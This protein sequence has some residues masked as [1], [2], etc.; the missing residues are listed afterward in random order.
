M[1]R[2]AGW[3]AGLRRAWPAAPTRSSCPSA[4]ST[5]TRSARTC[6]RRH[7]RGPHVLDR[8]RQR[9]RA[10][11]ATARHD[12]RRTPRPTRSATCASAA[13]PS[14]S[15]SEIEQ[16]TGYETRMTILG[17]V[18][19]G[20][21]PTAYDRV[22]ATRFGVEAVDAPTRGE[23]GAMVALRG[24]DIVDACRWPRRSP[25]PSCSTP[26]STRP[27]RSSSGS[28][29][30]D[31]LPDRVATL[32]VC[33]ACGRVSSSSL[34][35]SWPPAAAPTPRP[36]T[37]TSTRSTRP[38]ASS[39]RS[40][41]SSRARSPRRARAAQDRQ[42]LDGF[43]QAIDKVV[44]DFRAV[45][46]PSKVKPL[47]DKLIAEVSGLRRA[48]RQGQGRLLRQRPAGDRQGAGRSRQR[49]DEGPGADQPDDR[50]HQQEAAR[51]ITL[52]PCS[53]A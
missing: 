50:G 23:S 25:S 13:S 8:R 12:D 16:R 6:A 14:S 22:L 1:G 7:A 17:H 48:D 31:R 35:R 15:S 5:S 18:Q 41:T 47:H 2:H 53:R 4:R 45:K 52:G 51:V 11:R 32:A 3:I 37:T 33:A 29:P 20:G 43:R 39:R 42:T 24:T 34:S 28:R 19:R 26:S 46:A 36:P 10:R 30:P 21:T 44:A 49:G 27:P 40:S 38:R 9:G